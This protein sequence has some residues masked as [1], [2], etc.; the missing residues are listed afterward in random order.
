MKIFDDAEER[1]LRVGCL[2][3]MGI[4][5]CAKLEWKLYLFTWVIIYE[6]KSFFGTLVFF[7]YNPRVLTQDIHHC[8]IRTEDN[9]SQGH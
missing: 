6:R 5:A 1:T 3:L 8:R 7:I 9:S 4:K 2:K